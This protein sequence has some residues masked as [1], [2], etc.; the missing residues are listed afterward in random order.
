M[1]HIVGHTYNASLNQGV[2]PTQVRSDAAKVCSS[3]TGRVINVL[4]HVGYR[5]VIQTVCLVIPQVKTLI[6]SFLC[7]FFLSFS[8]VL[9]F[10]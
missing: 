7:S 5:N 1:I 10:M 6:L 9:S 2:T 3:S 4:G 8:L